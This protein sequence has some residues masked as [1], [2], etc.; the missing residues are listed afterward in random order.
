M[1]SLLLA[2]VAAAPVTALTLVKDGRPAAVIVTAD[3]PSPAAQQGAAALAEWLRLA[4]GATLPVVNEKDL[5]AGAGTLI[6]V[7][8]TA[9]TAAA[10]LR[11]ADLAPEELRVRTTDGALLLVGN[12]VRPDGTALL[13]TLWAVDEFAE[14]YLGARWLWPGELGRVVKQQAT[15]EVGAID[16]AFTPVLKQRRIRNSHYNDRVQRGLDKLG[17][18]AEQFQQY[19]RPSGAWFDFQRIGGRFNGTYGHAYAGYW[20]RFAKDHP[21]W[22]AQQPDGT[23]DNSKAAAGHRERLCVSNEELV[24]QVAA[25]K[26]AE[27]KAKPTLDCA[28]ISPNDG[29]AASFCQ[30]ARCQ[31]L[32]A[33]DGAMIETWG[34]NGPLQHVSLTDRYVHFYRAV[35]ELVAKEL[36]DRY[37]GCYAY[38]AY[39]YAP[40]RETLPGNVIIGIVDFG[41]LNEAE[42]QRARQDWLAWSKSAKALFWRPN[43]LAA[44]MGLPTVYVHRLAEDVRFCQEHGMSVTDF[45]CCYHNWATDGL[46]YY[47][48]ARLLWDP[49]LD[50]DAVVDDFCQAGFGPAAGALRRYFNRLEK[51]TTELAD[52]NRYEGR[53]DTPEV[54]A[55]CYTDELLAELRAT[56][57]EATRLAAGDPDIT[58]RI[59]FYRQPLD[60]V[61]IRRDWTFAKQAKDAKKIKE[62]EAER[63]EWYRR[64]GP[65]WAINSAYMQF[66]GY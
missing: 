1:R 26:I 16:L 14:R 63:L 36:P 58:A 11:S 50:V 37:L 56:L 2:C 17:W 23:R 57:D 20:E 30:C 52:S 55:A 33:P 32:D 12:D 51:M 5:P 24:K 46:N 3:Q 41:Y 48:L 62:L 4:S 42:R 13:G 40:K 39:R 65:T 18:T 15:I 64:Q 8:D 60:Y 45:D 38:S 6:L 54:L 7:G 49:T 22:F 9:R 43:L 31:A 21:D 34:P 28:S 47:V 44:G 35:A 61:R 29:G 59:D 53:K 66:Y 19:Q 27:L 10:G 25:D